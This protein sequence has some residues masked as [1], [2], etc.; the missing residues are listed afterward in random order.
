[1]AEL[2]HEGCMLALEVKNIA[3]KK[4]EDGKVTMKEYKQVLEEDE[5]VQKKI[6][7]MK[8]VVESFAESFPLP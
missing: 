3:L 4:K 8:F 6:R 1:M 7:E 5:G 2:L